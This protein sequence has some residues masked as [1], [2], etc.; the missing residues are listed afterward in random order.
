MPLLFFALIGILLMSSTAPSQTIAPGTH[1][2]TFQ[3]TWDGSIEPYNLFVPTAHDTATSLPLVVVLHGKG[4]TWESWF[5]ATDVREWAESEGF[6]VAAPHGRGNWFYLGPGEQDTLDVI[7]E[8]KSLCRIDEERIYLLGHSMGGWGVWHLAAARPD[9]FAAIV[10]MATWPPAELLANVRNLAPLIIHGLKDETVH[11][12]GSERAVNHLK[13]LGIEHRYIEVPEAGHESRM[14]NDMFPEIGD[15][16]RDRRRTRDPQ[17]VQVRAFS[18]R[19]GQHAWVSLHEAMEFTRVAAIDAVAHPGRLDIV[20]S[21]VRDFALMIPPHA[22]SD[23]RSV[24]LS[25]DNQQQHV[26]VPAKN[27]IILVKHS[28]RG[29]MAR[30][31]TPDQFPA[32]RAKVVGRVEPEVDLPAIAGRIVARQLGVDVVLLPRDLIAPSLPA[33]GILTEDII[34]DL[35]M[36]PEDEMCRIDISRD[37]YAALVVRKEWYPTWWGEMVVATH[38]EEW[39]EGETISVALPLAVAD[40]LPRECLKLGVS[41]RKIIHDHVREHKTLVLY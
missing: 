32:P 31:G 9:L 3:A 5:A 25:I 2:L 33:D 36:R 29:W 41:F 37:E 26:L 40:R 38:D 27:R 23:S 8:A 4:A 35:F 11:P 12:A 34:L 13:I 17:S 16:I 18:P 22:A 6:V 39:E 28:P 14:I 20:T 7:N 24:L 21:N 1:P 30:L 15:W 19:R 10:P